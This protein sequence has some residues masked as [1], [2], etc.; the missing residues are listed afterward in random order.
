MYVVMV[1]GEDMHQAL[2]TARH[3]TGFILDCHRAIPN[4]IRML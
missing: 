3:V 4:L 2:S 1:L